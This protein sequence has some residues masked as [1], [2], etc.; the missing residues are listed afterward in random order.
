MR[1]RALIAM[2]LVISMTLGLTACGG[3]D[4]YTGGKEGHTLI[5]DVNDVSFELVSAV[6]RNAT[7]VTNIS[8][9]MEFEKEQ[10][11]LYKDGG[12]SYFLFNMGSI[13][14]V[15]Q[16]GTNFDF[17]NS[18]DKKATMENN[19]LLG[20]WFTSPKKKLDFAENEKN[21]I[22]K[23]MGT[24]T[25]QVTLTSNLYEDFAGKLTVINDGM[26]E[27]SM[28]IG[29]IGSNFYEL[30]K[31]TQK[32]IAYMAAT[33]TKYQKPDMPA[34]PTPAVSLGGESEATQTPV[35][36]QAPTVMPTTEPTTTPVE[37]EESTPEA[38]SVD[39]EEPQEET[40]EEQ[41]PTPTIEPTPEQTTKLEEIE[42]AITE[43]EP[44]PTPD[45]KRGQSIVLD[46]QK[47]T[48]K[49]DNTIYASTVYD[50]LEVGK[51]GYLSIYT[52]NGYETA[53]MKLLNIYKG[54]EAI[55][56]IKEADQKDT[57]PDPY[58]EPADGCTW[59][60]AQYSV[61][62]TACNSTGYIDVRLRGMDGENLRLRG[63]EYSQRTYAITIS[64]NEYYCFYEVPN[65]CKEYVLE[66]GEGTVDNAEKGVLSAYYKIS[67]K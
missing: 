59:H 24:A 5:D 27:W 14:C 48:V 7:A 45:V 62:T 23:F 26:Q 34:T 25:A 65:G 57:M 54:K 49:D 9:E 8:E 61:D 19:N 18:D 51:R 39:I 37:V 47:K 46:N 32:E 35:A 6:S 66:C 31:E 13:V 56:I 58:F 30:D 55:S 40:E 43:V 64:E 17:K 20:V 1:I 33:L 42:I 29:S 67:Q 41:E 52:D 38:I 50:L 60:V 11:Y 10:T 53:N 63:I 4:M 36:T 12:S 2:I 16:K 28:F 15:V 44:T 22:Y 3:D 21:G